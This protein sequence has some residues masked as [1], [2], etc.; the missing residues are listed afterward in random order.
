MNAAAPGGAPPRLIRTI[1]KNWTI[2]HHQIGKT[3][4]PLHC[5]APESPW[6]G[7]T[8]KYDF[9]ASDVNSCSC[10]FQQSRTRDYAGK[11]L[12]A[13]PWFCKPDEDLQKFFNIP[14]NRF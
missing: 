9:H 7:G 3:S 10:S 13:Q 4:L 1:Q 11:N 12:P 8:R 14:D 2:G 6:S 5:R